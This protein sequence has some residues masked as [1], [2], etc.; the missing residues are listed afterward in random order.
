MRMREY[1]KVVILLMGIIIFHESGWGFFLERF[2][3]NGEELDIL[4]PAVFSKTT[5]NQDHSTTTEDSLVTIDFSTD[6]FD[7]KKL[8][9]F[10]VYRFSEMCR[11]KMSDQDLE[12]IV[13]LGTSEISLENF[14]IPASRGNNGNDE[15]SSEYIP[16]SY[17]PLYENCNVN[18]LIDSKKILLQVTA[19]YSIDLYFVIIEALIPIREQNS[20]YLRVA[21]AYIFAPQIDYHEK[22][23][24]TEEESILLRHWGH[25]DLMDSEGYANYLLCYFH[26]AL[27]EFYDH[28]ITQVT[29]NE[30]NIPHKIEDLFKPI[31]GEII[32]AD[33]DFTPK[34]DNEE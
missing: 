13:F 3:P 18:S 23:K 27:Y 7:L 10:C 29:F 6:E 34:F 12:S 31:Q 28:P 2:G 8:R 19:S 33:L 9:D 26:P 22:G 17:Y 20:T 32:R 1:F 21:Q 14:R 16:F 4:G 25:G 30:S 24:G 15:N 11:E 5:F